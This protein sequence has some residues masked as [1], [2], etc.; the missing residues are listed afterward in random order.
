MAHVKKQVRQIQTPDGI[1]WYTET[2]TNANDDRAGLTPEYI[3]LIPSGEGDCQSHNT[4]AR[5]LAS[6]ETGAYTVLTF[7][8][9]GMSRTSAPPEAYASVTPKLLARQIVGL[10]EKL[11]IGRATL[12]GSSSGGSATLCIVGSRPDLV[13]CA[14]V[15]EIP[16]ADAGPMDDMLEQPDDEISGVCRNL[17]RDVF[18]EQ[19][20][21]DGRQRWDALGQEYHARLAKN[22]VTWVRHFSPDGR[23]WT[24]DIKALS[25]EQFHQRPVFWTVGGL[26]SAF[27]L[28]DAKGIWTKNFLIAESAGLVINRKRLNCLHFPHVTI[29]NNLADWILECTRSVRY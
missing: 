21:N 3:V 23:K 29:P 20:T 1:S 26:N 7:D 27:Q 24:E 11:A 2:F 6:S 17:F 16:I 13:K 19:G 8:M 25:P 15:H 9:P 10:L 22:Y 18:I 5:L 4:V 28:E 14:I 12:F